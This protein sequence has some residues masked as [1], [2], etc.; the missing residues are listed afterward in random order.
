[1]KNLEI[2][3]GVDDQNWMAGFRDFTQ[4]ATRQE[5]R[6]IVETGQTGACNH[7]DY[8]PTQRREIQ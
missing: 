1:M 7:L 5:R 4:A 8:N 3:P 6:R 2:I